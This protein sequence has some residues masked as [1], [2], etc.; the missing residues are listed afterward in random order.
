MNRLII[1]LSEFL[2]WARS[3]HATREVSCAA[4]LPVVGVTLDGG[5]RAPFDAGQVRALPCVLVGLTESKAGSDAS[6]RSL[7]DVLVPSD[8]FDALAE[9]V[10]ANP[11][12][13]TT[14]ALL[15]R[16]S[17]SRSWE[18]GLVAESAA[19]SALQ[20][21]SEFARWRQ[22][23][24]ARPITDAGAPRVAF[25]R[26]GGELRIRLT[27]PARRNAIDNLMRDALDDA[28]ATADDAQLERV[29]LS[30]EGASFCAGGD[31]D[32]FGTRADPA[33]AHLVRLS[34][35]PSR[36][37][38]LASPRLEARVHGACIG[39]GIELAAFASRV[40][41]APDSFFALPEVAMGLI[42]GAG[43]TVSIARRI[44]RQRTAWLALSNQS[45]DAETALAWGLI[46]AIDNFR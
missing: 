8:G 36:R 27:R 35:S 38:A 10:L 31:L 3:P 28:L 30:G 32:E 24:P 6:L 26:K 14:L 20:S 46:D 39:S 12:A 11:V 23:H 9:K 29:V 43:G 42:P 1:G 44:N 4:G 5:L 22:A 15:L 45:I 41:A 25:T 2:Q 17:D 18:E 16:H 40:V 21:G 37:M 13:A 33:R 34:C 7:F 19:Y